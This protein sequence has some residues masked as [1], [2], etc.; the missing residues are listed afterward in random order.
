MLL[1]AQ[2][3]HAY[4]L[5][6]VPRGELIVRTARDGEKM[7][8]LDG[9]ERD[10]RRRDGARLRPRRPHGHRGGH[11][12][13]GLRGLRG[14][15]QRPARGGQLGRGQHP[16]H[17]RDAGPALGGLDPLR[18]A[19][20]PRDGDLGPAGGLAPPGRARPAPRWS[21]GR[22]T[23][24]PRSRPPTSSRSTGPASTRSWAS[25]SR[26]SAPSSTWRRSSSRSS[27]WATRDLQATVPLHRHYDV[28]READ[29]IEEVGRLEGFDRLPRPLPACAR[30]GRRG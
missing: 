27:R 23:T 11:G 12:R 18:E 8:T 29:L 20:S 14:D 15:R 24:R 17:L 6:K 25:R 10:P 1:T 22:S 2:P 13:A 19:A 26:A 16:A 9:V 5:D 28:T 4:D 7:T 3:L 21:R 30:A